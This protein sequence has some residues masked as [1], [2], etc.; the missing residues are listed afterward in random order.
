MSRSPYLVVRFQILAVP[1]ESA[2]WS[3]GK[4]SSPARTFA[5]SALS[6]FDSRA[7]LS[8]VDSGTMST[9]SVGSG[10]PW[11]YAA[12]PPIKMQSTRCF[13]SACMIRS[14][15]KSGTDRLPHGGQASNGPAQALRALGR[16]EIC[17]RIGLTRIRVV[18][19]RQL[20]DQLEAAEP[21]QPFHGLQ[22]RR[23]ATG[24]EP[25][26]GRLRRAGAVR[27]HLLR[28]ARAP[29]TFANE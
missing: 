14:G 24:L 6:A 9:S 27:Q 28:D 4:A 25:G 19:R 11:R 13:A 8:G 3:N 17:H 15:S 5:S 18:V 12:I 26:D 29:P 7:R 23:G 21:Q 2:S 1:N 10:E 22:R 16:R 20:D